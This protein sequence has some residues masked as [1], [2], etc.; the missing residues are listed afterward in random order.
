MPAQKPIKR[1][2]EWKTYKKSG[3]DQNGWMTKASV[4]FHNPFPKEG[5]DSEPG[6]HVTQRHNDGTEVLF[7]LETVNPVRTIVPIHNSL[8]F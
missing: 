6:P 3:R 7:F 1:K 8:M 4:D 5:Q 2:G